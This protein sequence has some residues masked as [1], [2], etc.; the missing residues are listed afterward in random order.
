MDTSAMH[1]KKSRKR[2]RGVNHPRGKEQ[3][4][5][6]HTDVQVPTQLLVTTTAP[7]ASTRFMRETPQWHQTTAMHKAQRMRR[8][9]QPGLLTTNERCR[10][11]TAQKGGV[12]L[13]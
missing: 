11:V 2:N 13:F 8:C 10:G 4:T 7:W 12:A 1:G 6:Q 5:A 9:A 3:G